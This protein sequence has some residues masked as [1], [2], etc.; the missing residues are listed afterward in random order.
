M[1]GG[2]GGAFICPSM[3][4]LLEKSLF[5][6]FTNHDHSHI[7]PEHLEMVR[8]LKGNP[9]LIWGD[10]PDWQR[11]AGLTSYENMLTS[12]FLLATCMAAATFV[13][14]GLA[15]IG[16]KRKRPPPEENNSS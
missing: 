10:I 2:L 12:V 16:L 6:Q 5:E 3:L 15:V 7:T 11:E 8:R 9:L 13:L 1:A 14:Q 4:K